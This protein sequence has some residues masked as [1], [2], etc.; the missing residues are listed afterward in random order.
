[1]ADELQGEALG[2]AALSAGRVD[3]GGGPSPTSALLGHA[4]ARFIERFP[5]VSMRLH[6]GNWDDLVHPLRARTLDFFV[7]ETSLLTREPDLD[8]AALPTRHPLYFVARAGHPLVADAGRL[9]A[10]DILEWPFATPSRIAPRALEPLLAAYREGSARHAMPHP[11]PAVECNGLEPLKRMVLASDLVTATILPCIA[12]ELA[13]GTMRVLGT[14]PW[15]HLHYGIVSL[16][17]RPW[18]QAAEAMRDLVLEAERNAVELHARLSR[19]HDPLQRKR[20]A[21]P[22]PKGKRH[23]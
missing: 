17:G 20:R 23:A 8:V 3:V 12:E 2:H 6:A 16:R 11:F 1:M 19:R 7:A 9:S 21:A 5:R 22:A 10:A 4:A 15:M 14:E 13:Q 18:T